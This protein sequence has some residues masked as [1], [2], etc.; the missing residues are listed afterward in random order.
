M[1]VTFQ[2][3]TLMY[4]IFRLFGRIVENSEAVY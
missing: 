1:A 2:A 4:N 3:H